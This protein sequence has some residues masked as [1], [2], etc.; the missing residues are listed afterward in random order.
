Y[1]QKSKKKKVLELY[2]NDFGLVE[3]ASKEQF[4]KGLKEF[5][6]PL[7]LTAKN[8]GFEMGWKV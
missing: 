2:A 4:Q 8:Q 1:F 3:G 5:Y 6:A 7:Y